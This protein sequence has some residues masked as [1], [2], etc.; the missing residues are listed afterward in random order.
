VAGS[1]FLIGEV[2]GQAAEKQHDFM[3]A[4]ARPADSIK[5]HAPADRPSTR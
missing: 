1:L 5:R 2:L 3:A 4:F